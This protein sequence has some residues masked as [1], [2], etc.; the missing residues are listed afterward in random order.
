MRSAGAR[1]VWWRWVAAGLVMAGCAGAVAQAPGTGAIAGT[2][3]DPRGAVM[4]KAEVKAA[5][6]STGVTRTAETNA[7]G[8]F[9]MTLLSPGNYTVTV[10]D[11]GF[12]DNA[13]HGVIV[14]VG[15]TEALNFTLAVQQADVN[16]QVHADEEIAQLDTTTL[17]RAVDQAAVEALPLAT[18]NFTQILSLSPG[19]AV[20]LPNAES[21]GHGSQN[22]ADNGAKTTANNVQFNGVDA[23]NLAQNSAENAG[24]EV[25]IAVPAP[26]TIA[27]FK[28]QTANY[29]A[30][31]GRGVG[32]NVDVVSRTGTNQFHGSVWEFLRNDVLNANLFFVKAQG[33]PRPELKHNQFGGA[34]GGPIWRDRAFFFGA[35]QGLREVNGVGVATTAVLPQ[36][37]ADRSAATLGAQFCPYSTSAGGT[38]IAC[39]GSN[40]SPVALKLLNFKLANGQYAIPSPQLNLPTGPGELPIGQT[41]Y[42]LPATYNEDQYTANLDANLTSGNQAAARFFYS[43]APTKTP[44]APNAATVPGWG[45][46]EVDKNAMLVMSDTQV[47]NP[48]LV[49][50]FRFGYM[51][52][53][54][55][56]AVANPISA[57]TV[58]MQGPTGATAGANMPGIMV[59]GLFILG[60]AGTPAQSQLTN[61][62]IWQNTLSWT[63]GR[64]SV[65]AGVEAKRHQVLV[66]APFSIDGLVEAGSFNDF[67]LGQS[68]AQNGSPDGLSNLLFSNGSSGF[69]R[70]DERYTDFASFVQDDIKANSRLTVNAGVR[71][72][73]FGPPSETHGRLLTFDPA[74]AT[75]GAPS[76]GTLSGFEVPANFQ[77]TLPTGVVRLGHNGV[78][79]TT[80]HDVS[81]R[82]GFALQLTQH[83]ML[84][85]RGGAGLYFERL[86]A[87]MIEGSLGQPPF[88][89]SEFVF[90]AQNGAASLASPF[91]P[92]LPPNS[93]YPMFVPRTPDGTLLLTADNPHMVDSYTEEYNLN[94]Q[95]APARNTLVEAGYVGT[96]SLHIA[97]SSMFNQ[98]KLASPTHPVNGETTNTQGNAQARAPFLGLSE[99]SL[100]QDTRYNGNYNSL[101][102]S[103]TQRM[104]HGL[105]F[106]AS[107]TWGK[108]LNETSG[109]SGGDMYELWLYTNDQTNPRQA[110][111]LS[112]FDRS[113]RGVLSLIY[114]TPAL[115]GTPRV[116][117]KAL[118][119]WQLSGIAV[120]QSGTPLT[121]ID[122]TAGSVYGTYPFE[123]RAQLSGKAIATKGSIFSRVHNGY[124][125]AAGFA[126]PPEAPFGSGPGDTD[127]GNS[128]TGI[129]RGP[130]QRNI[131]M[132]VERSFP[133]EKA[134]ALRFRAEF[135]NLT[136]TTNFSN[137]DHTVTDGPAFGTITSA[138]NNPRIA[139][140]A[141]RYQF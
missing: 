54:G 109:S 65:S 45:N 90:G 56:E 14:T 116:L 111:G 3:H 135:F 51:R 57:A 9:S 128:G 67:L 47:V 24:E 48:R 44:F 1:R 53:D 2:V 21:L 70:R 122:Q 129:V 96:R 113:N 4:A 62:F 114:Q 130:G 84:V 49:N 123:Q 5:N 127:F 12:A 101:Q 10:S 97:G 23:N 103:V 105:E 41:T 99:A 134:G 110:Y 58:G 115:H 26:D 112:D 91:N 52:F 133:I 42:T 11:G 138:A 33:S 35:Y 87:G 71:W 117:R 64:Q 108:S 102:A 107:Y 37:T 120:A 89:L 22:V 39:N 95:Y 94:L 73:V 132:A 104:S 93:A 81:P 13:L 119:N 98:A 20:A 139:Q 78:W 131:D 38:Q 118:G 124:L 68:A 61:S 8:T 72:E 43:S 140:F 18:R 92:P 86:P 82:L 80:Y 88:S 136:N 63:H 15:E 79:A 77:G 83:P 100:N 34:L 60:D 46:D 6:E 50:V 106:L 125:D 27:E 40:I 7:A 74:I 30:S 121:I 17:G 66:N 69:F 16:V 36:L 28:V 141:L 75:P 76:T 19:V 55:H 31:Y 137:P 32:A 59:N 85:L 126:P 25:G 29:D